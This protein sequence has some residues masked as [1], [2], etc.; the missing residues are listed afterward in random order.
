M[1]PTELVL[2][3]RQRAEKLALAGNWG[4][5]TLSV[6]GELLEHDPDHL[7]A[8]TRVARCHQEAGN[9]LAQREWYLRAQEDGPTGTSKTIVER[10]LIRVNAA[11]RGLGDV[12]ALGR[13]TDVSELLSLALA[14]REARRPDL[15]LALAANTRALEIAERAP[16]VHPRVRARNG[17]GAT[18]RAR[19]E[20]E[21]ALDQA[22][23]SREL[24]GNP[25][26][27]SHAFTV[28][29]AALGDQRNFTQAV[30]LGESVMRSRPADPYLLNAMMRA[31]HGAGDLASAESCGEKALALAENPP[32]RQRAIK[33]LRKIVVDH[34]QRG[35]TVRAQA[36][37]RLLESPAIR[38]PAR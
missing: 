14:V 3:L 25:A 26:R 36:L 13:I 10:G 35:N 30:E 38:S 23:K 11:L 33:G 16:D 19:G 4:P 24:D 2:Q 1:E 6:N 8:Y 32:A 12:E 29:I 31:Y 18:L 9:L 37:R 22:R 5:E 20:S 7:P 27:N 28:A 21:A 15:D 34:E 17:L